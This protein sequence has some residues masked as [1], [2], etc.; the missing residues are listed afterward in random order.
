LSQADANALGGDSNALARCSRL[1]PKPTCIEDT[2]LSLYFLTALTAKHL[3]A[4][5]VLDI[6]TLSKRLRLPGS[7]VEDV[8]AH[9]RTEALVE[10]RA[11][12]DESLLLRF[13]LTD[14]GRVL[15]ADAFQRDGYLG[16]APV[17]MAVYRDLVRAQ[18]LNN[19]PV[20]RARVHE[21]FSD[22]V[23]P[24][25]TLDSLGPAM[26]SGRAM[27]IY[28]M[29]GTGKTYIA[30][31]LARLLGPPVLVPHAI[32]VDDS[33][34]EYFDPA[35]HKLVPGHQNVDSALFAEGFDARFVF[36]ERPFVSSGGELTA[37]M[38]ELQYDS[39]SRRYVAP[40]QMRANMGMLLIDDLGRQR[41]GTADLFNR[42]IVPLEE[43]H[44]QLTLHTGRHFTT[45]FDLVLIFSTNIDPHSLADDAFL[46]R[47]GYKIHFR[48]SSATEYGEIWRR[49]CD[50]N[51]IADDGVLLSHV[52]DQLYTR[53]GIP[54]LACHPRDLLGLALDYQRYT[55]QERVQI[56]AIDWAW[57][58]YFVR[59]ESEGES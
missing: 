52:L 33:V 9:M 23:I 21:A 35:A 36:C 12:R 30:R 51:G 11:S 25:E 32:I 16:P 3:A 56:D 13:G 39:T 5:G 2:G 15:A 14:R 53:R 40:L 17:P 4:A 50:E 49:F 43:K 37:D 47:I 34:I 19:I 10:L 26:S 29:P 48:P 6:V 28:G 42:W 58:N 22:I 45:P 7:I 55:S 54:K 57:R 20:T 1:A 44:D 18:S 46:R 27:F 41:I 38:L 24:E 8:L 31:H 59:V